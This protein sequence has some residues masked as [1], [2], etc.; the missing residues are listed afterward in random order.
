MKVTYTGNIL[1]VETEIPVAVAK[2]AGGKLVARDEQGKE[3]FAVMSNMS[4]GSLSRNGIGC[5]AVIDNMLAC[6]IIKPIGT[7]PAR[8]KAE[9]GDAVVVANTQVPAILVAESARVAAIDELI[10]VTDTT[11]AE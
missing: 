8:I 4:E 5:N 11:V 1:T 6:V 7:T 10:E 9:Y 2:A 3:V